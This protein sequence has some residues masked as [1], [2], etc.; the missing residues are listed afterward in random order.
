[1]YCWLG[2]SCCGDFTLMPIHLWLCCPSDHRSYSRTAISWKRFGCVPSVMTKICYIAIYIPPPEHFPLTYFS[3]GSNCHTIPNGGT[4]YRKSPKRLL[5][6]FW[7]SNLPNKI[8]QNFG[9]I[10]SI[11]MH[12]FISNPECICPHKGVLWSSVLFDTCNSTAV[13]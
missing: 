3:A 11:H 1:M 7:Q 10:Q 5:M 2:G 13:R 6:P 12:W 8:W 9:F 4:D